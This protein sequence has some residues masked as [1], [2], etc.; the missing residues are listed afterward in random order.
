MPASVAGFMA[1]KILKSGCL[2]MDSRS[3]RSTSAMLLLSLSM[4]P[5]SLSSACNALLHSP[6]RG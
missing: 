6:Q 1:A 4:M 2:G 3:P 5:A